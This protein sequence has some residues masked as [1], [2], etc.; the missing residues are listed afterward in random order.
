VLYTEDSKDDFSEF[1]FSPN[2]GASYMSSNNDFVASA[3]KSSPD[4]F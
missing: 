3:L 1:Y 2:E 4:K